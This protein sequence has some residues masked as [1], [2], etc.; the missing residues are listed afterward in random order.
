MHI[1]QDNIFMQIYCFKF[2]SFYAIT[3]SC[4][5]IFSCAIIF[6]FHAKK[7]HTITIVSNVVVFMQLHFHANSSFYAITFSCKYIVSYIAV[8]LQL[9]FCANILILI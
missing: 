6:Y 1:E 4:K 9:H 5:Y 3:F 8:F 7:G 2:S